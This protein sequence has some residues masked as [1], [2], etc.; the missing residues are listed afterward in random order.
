MVSIVIFIVKHLVWKR[1]KITEIYLKLGRGYAWAGQFRLIANI[2]GLNSF[3]PSVSEENFGIDPPIGAINCQTLFQQ[4]VRN[5]QNNTRDG[6]FCKSSLF[7][8]T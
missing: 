5:A 6:Q 2:A 1:Y 3:D 8:Q 4:R 7:L